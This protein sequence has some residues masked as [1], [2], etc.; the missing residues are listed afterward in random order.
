VLAG[1]GRGYLREGGDRAPNSPTTLPARR[2]GYVEESDL[3]G[4]YAG[5]RAVVMPSLYEG[6][7]LPCLEGMA[8]GTP[9]VCAP[10]AALPETCGDA[11]LMADPADESAFTE[12]VMAAAVDEEQR[13]RLIAAGLARART[14]SW[15]RT[16]EMTDA[17]ISRALI[18]PNRAGW[19]LPLE[20]GR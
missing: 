7:G 6:F 3:P 14:Y 15:Q 5:A 11:A 9:V 2:L 18:S 13:A 12:A 8:S 16:A 20:R 17:A 19:R 10:F 4:L 1:S